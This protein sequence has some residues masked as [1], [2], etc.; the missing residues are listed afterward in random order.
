MLRTKK[1]KETAKTKAKTAKEK[2]APKTRPNP[3][4]PEKN[5][6]ENFGKVLH[7]P[8]TPTRNPTITRKRM[9]E[10]LFTRYFIHLRTR[11]ESD[12][13]VIYTQLTPM[14][15]FAISH[16]TTSYN[17]HY[18]NS[19]QGDQG[20]GVS[21]TPILPGIMAL[22]GLI[23]YTHKVC[24]IIH[25]L[26]LSPLVLVCPGMS[27]YVLVSHGMSMYDYVVSM[28]IGMGLVSFV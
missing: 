6:A 20:S 23:G 16:S 27:W 2:R 10:E 19:T 5:P 8:T 3:E 17:I 26:P 15:D 22:A 24:P 1:A 14:G 11:G 18:V 9:E 12:P 4:K 25:P 28:S 7:A 13:I 21:S